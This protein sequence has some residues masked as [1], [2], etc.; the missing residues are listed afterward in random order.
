MP[1][2]QAH[3]AAKFYDGVGINVH[4]H[5]TPYADQTKVRDCLAALNITH[6]RDLNFAQNSTGWTRI[7]SYMDLGYKFNFMMTTDLGSMVEQIATFAQ[8]PPGITT[9]EG[10]NEDDITEFHRY[11]GDPNVRMNGSTGDGFPVGTRAWQQDLFNLINA[12][13]AL[14]QKGVIGPSLA[15][16]SSYATLGDLSPYCDYGNSHSYFSGGTNPGATR[17]ENKQEVVL[18]APGRPIIATEGG[19]HTGTSVTTGNL[20]IS[21]A[22]HAKYMPRFLCEQYQHGWVR[23]YIYELLNTAVNLGSASNNWGLFNTDGSPKPAATAV[24]AL[25]GLM[26]DSGAPIDHA[27]E[28][29]DFTLTGMPS[30][31]QW[32]VFQKQN[33]TFYLLMWNEVRNWTGDNGSAINVADVSITLTINN[34]S[35][36][37]VRYYKVS[38]SG[39]T[40]TT[41]NPATASWGL[42]LP[43][44][45]MVVEL[46]PSGGVVQPPPVEEPEPP[47]VGVGGS[48]TVR[49]R[50]DVFALL[51]DNTTGAI[52]AQDVRDAVETLYAKTY[53]FSVKEF[54]AIGDGASHPLSS[55]YGSLA[56]A[57]VDYPHAQALTDELDWAGTQ[58]AINAAANAYGGTVYSP[59]GDYILNRTVV[60]PNAPEGAASQVQK[61]ITWQGDCDNTRYQW[62]SNAPNGVTLASHANDSTELAH[63]NL[64]DLT[65]IGPGIT[66]QAAG[67]WM[68]EGMYMRRCF[69]RDWKYAVSINGGPRVLDRVW[70]GR[71]GVDIYYRQRNTAYASR[72]LYERCL[73][74][75]W[76]A[77][78]GCFLVHPTN[79]ITGAFESCNFGN[80]GYVFAKEAGDGSESPHA[81]QLLHTVYMMH[82]RCEGVGNSFMIDFNQPTTVGI[83]AVHMVSCTLRAGTARTGIRSDALFDLGYIDGF[84]N[85]QPGSMDEWP[86]RTLSMFKVSGRVRGTHIEGANRFANT[87]LNAGKQFFIGTH[88]TMMGG[89]VLQ[90]DTMSGTLVPVVT[91]S[92]GRGQSVTLS[93]GSA[94]P[95]GTGT[96]VIG[97]AAQAAAAGSAVYVITRGQVSAQCTGT[98]ASGSWVKISS[99]GVVAQAANRTDG[100]VVG[101]AVSGSSGG[102]VTIMVEP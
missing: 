78:D 42:G 90:G 53:S 99:N 25:L 29:L 52:S 56:A 30:S 77:G 12:N 84:R 95:A 70:F 69:L 15:R 58:A 81:T 45:L 96:K 79:V 27:T 6:I 60:L 18:I 14:S 3:P 50:N 64:Q 2:I 63:H 33:K 46:E 17:E 22:V 94:V 48:G 61:S 1:I 35:L 44:S 88:L 34:R 13:S 101:C 9:L 28:S 62:T 8:Y 10:S 87:A 37:A 102:F 82:C 66:L 16:G 40:P 93:G 47:P 19:Y 92:I 73:F 80:A 98:V 67:V 75:Q 100:T 72:T 21:Q 71:N 26:R 20:G 59:A 11:T 4:L 83:V 89:A 38:V 76:Q 24:G 57:Q 32:L 91:G 85:T 41:L 65:L 55:R 5:N 54:G 31:G 97:V 7:K 43:D 49:R 23:T 51:P 36:Q 39:S 86:A 74:S 68:A